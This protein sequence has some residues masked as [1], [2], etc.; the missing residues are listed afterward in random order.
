VSPSAKLTTVADKAPSDKRVEKLHISFAPGSLSVDP[1][2]K[3]IVNADFAAIAIVKDKV[4]G[5]TLR[6]VHYNLTPVELER[7]AHSGLGFDDTLEVP[8]GEYEVRVA[9]RD[10]NSG[11]IG[12][13]RTHLVVP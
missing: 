11:K 2:K 7:L 1:D 4:I 3:N 13:I 12:T 9:V 6:S 10:L 5:E 8:A